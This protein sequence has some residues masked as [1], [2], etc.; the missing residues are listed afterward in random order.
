MAL[1]RVLF[2]KF[3]LTAPCR[4][5]DSGKDRGALLGSIQKGTKLKKTVTVDKSGVF[6]VP[7]PVPL[8]ALVD[9]A[10]RQVL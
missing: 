10:F 8:A 5:K 1:G 7:V 9:V 6:L 3:R 4:I 2:A